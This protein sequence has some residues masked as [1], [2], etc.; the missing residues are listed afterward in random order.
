M[1]ILSSFF[2]WETRLRDD[3]FKPLAGDHTYNGKV[4]RNTEME[5]GKGKFLRRILRKS[6]I[7][8]V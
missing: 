3:V 8:N 7:D 2:E 6:I 5:G 4:D 1:S